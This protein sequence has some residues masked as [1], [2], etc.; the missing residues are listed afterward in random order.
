MISQSDLLLLKGFFSAYFH[1]DWSRD[2]ESPTSVVKRFVAVATRE[3]RT[4]LASAIVKYAAGFPTDKQLG[5]HLFRDLGCYYIPSG[6]GMSCK[7]WLE[8]IAE[9]LR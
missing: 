7:V 4:L 9:E 1:E 6:L 3:E 8:D 5:E 2:D